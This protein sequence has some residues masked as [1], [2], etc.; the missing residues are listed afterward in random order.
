MKNRKFILIFVVAVL[1]VLIFAYKNRLDFMSKKTQIEN[2]DDEEFASFIADYVNHSGKGFSSVQK[3]LRALGVEIEKSSLLH[4]E[5]DMDMYMYIFKRLAKPQYYLQTYLKF[6]KT[7]KNPGTYD[8]LSIEW[9]QD[10]ASHWTSTCSGEIDKHDSS[11]RGMIV[12]Y[13][14]DG[15]IKAGDSLYATV[16]V[17]PEKSGI[18][19][20]SSKYAHTFSVNS[21]DKAGDVAKFKGIKKSGTQN[22]T[23]EVVLS[24]SEEVIY[25]K[26]DMSVNVY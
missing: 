10:T 7:P 18:L 24:D 11:Y 15:F 3:E 23:Y 9:N 17:T 8:F 25:L 5:T 21:S 20:F 12:Y 16:L 14:F 19:N 1:M 6:H 13:V 4:Q 26:Q 2:M 22:Y